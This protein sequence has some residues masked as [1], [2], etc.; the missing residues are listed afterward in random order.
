MPRVV[1]FEFFAQDPERAT[2]FYKEVFDWEFQQWEGPQPYWLATTGPDGQPGINGGISSEEGWFKG[3]VNTMDVPDLDS[4]VDKV[5]AAGG[6]VLLPKTAV[7][8]IGWLAYCADTE[9]NAF[10]M[11]Q[12]DESAA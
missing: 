12:S 9:G 1:H 7:P 3:T 5:T 6:K 10:G 11:M 2:R 8:G 4:F